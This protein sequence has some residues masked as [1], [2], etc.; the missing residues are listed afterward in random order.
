MKNV[1]KAVA[2]VIALTTV[3]MNLQA[4]FSTGSSNEER[5]QIPSPSTS[6]LFLEQVRVN[7]RQQAAEASYNLSIIAAKR[8]NLTLAATLIEEA[9]QINHSNLSYLT[10]AADIA[11][12]T[13]D[14]DKAK[15]YQ[16]MVLKI[17]RSEL[18]L[19]DLQV[20]MILDQLGAISVKQERYEEAWS[21]FQEGLQLREN[22]LGEKHMLVAVS[23]NRLAS[24]AIRQQRPTVAE[25][26]RKRSLD[27]TREVSGPRHVN[28]ATMLSNLADFYQSE[29]RF[30]EAES[31]YK[32]AISI[33]ADSPEASISKALSQQ[34]LGRLFLSQRRFDDAREQF[35]QVLLLL[36]QNYALDHPYIHQ[37]IRN[38]ASVDAERDSNAKKENMYEELVRELSFKLPQH[39]LR[40]ANNT[41]PLSES[42]TRRF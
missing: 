5:L 42:R 2:A 3:S 15:E 7:S 10:I 4:A 32:E 21:S 38:L 8:N 14:F 26:L 27:M 28:T 34:S 22:V 29:A 11:F 20:A 31:L 33:W 17:V 6:E 35:E 23:L 25:S 16:T 39:K 9:I 37:A 13:Q 12:L 18:E 41:L 19:D 36:K 40:T 1:L 24:L 30:V